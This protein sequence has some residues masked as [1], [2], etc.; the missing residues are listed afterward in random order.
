MP[1]T[2]HIVKVDMQKDKPCIWAIVNIDSP[3]KDRRFAVFGTGHRIPGGPLMIGTNRKDVEVQQSNGTKLRYI[4]TIQ[5]PPFV[6]HL[7][8]VV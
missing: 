3:L 8:E 5:Q 7:F 4:D 1:V 2:S 6:W